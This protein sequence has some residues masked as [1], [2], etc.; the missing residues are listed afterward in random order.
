MDNIFNK[1]ICYRLKY[2]LFF[3]IQ[4]KNTYTG[5]SLLTDII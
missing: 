2:K 5:E 3:I 1:I 4:E